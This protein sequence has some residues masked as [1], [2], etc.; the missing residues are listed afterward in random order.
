MNRRNFLIRTGV[1]IAAI[2]F[3]GPILASGIQSAATNTIVTGK[4]RKLKAVWSCEMA[5]DLYY[6]HG[7]K[8]EEELTALLKKSKISI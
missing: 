4:I 6:Y 2:P 5:E 1:S 7:I 8:A 3:I